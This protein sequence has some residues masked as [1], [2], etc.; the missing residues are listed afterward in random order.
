MIPQVG[1]SKLQHRGQGEFQ[2]PLSSVMVIVQPPKDAKDL[3]QTEGSGYPIQHG[4]L[5]T[6]RKRATVDSQSASHMELPGAMMPVLPNPS[7]TLESGF[8][9][10]VSKQSLPVPNS[11]Q[12]AAGSWML[13]LVKSSFFFGWR[14]YLLRSFRVDMMENSYPT[15]TG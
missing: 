12:P 10:E 11:E 2:N 1:P 9:R 15:P 3:T 14:F 13:I 4:C 5:H 7:V 6:T 8:A